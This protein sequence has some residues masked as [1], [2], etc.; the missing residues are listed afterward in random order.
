MDKSFK[1]NATGQELR[2]FIPA[3]LPNI[4]TRGFRARAITK[5]VQSALDELPNHRRG[6]N[7]SEIKSSQKLELQ[8]A[9]V[10]AVPLA[11]AEHTVVPQG[12]LWKKYRTTIFRGYYVPP[13]SYAEI[14]R[15]WC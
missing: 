7:T 14:L 10:T 1:L 6:S 2:G 12:Q 3:C 9:T 4:P 11:W 13:N 8:T 15:R 5:L